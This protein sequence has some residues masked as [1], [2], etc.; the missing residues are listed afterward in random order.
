MSAELVPKDST[1]WAGLTDIFIHQ[2]LPLWPK[3]TA[4]DTAQVYALIFHVG[5]QIEELTRSEFQGVHPL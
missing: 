1:S 2:D 3:L 5:Y 4:L